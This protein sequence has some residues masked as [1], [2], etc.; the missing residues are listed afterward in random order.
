M[1]PEPESPPLGFRTIPCTGVD[2]S[3]RLYVVT[4]G[5]V[6]T[7]RLDPTKLEATLS[8]LVMHKFPRAGARV[9]LYELQIPEKFDSQNPPFVFT[10]QEHPEMY[11]GNGRPEI[12]N[13]FTGS[14]PCIPP[15][16]ELARFFQSETCP[17]SLADF[18]ER[19][20][21]AI[22]IHVT[23]FEG[24]TF[25]GFIAPHIVF[26][27]IGVATLLKAW[28]RLLRGEAIEN[29][30]GME[31]DAQP[32]APFMT[33]LVESEVPRGCFKPGAPRPVESC[34]EQD[35]SPP[36][37]S[38]P[39]YVPRFVRVPKVF[40][41][42]A[43]RNIM[44]ELK[45]QG[46]TE[47]VGSSD[48]LTAWWLKTVYG[49]R[50]PGDDTPIHVHISRNLRG[51]PVFANDAP[52]KAPYIHNAVSMIPVP[53]IPAC[54]FQTE[55]LGALALHIRRS[56]ITYNADLADVR[57]NLRW[58]CAVPQSIDR[59]DVLLCPSG[60]EWTLSVNWRSSNFGDL[61]FSG[62]AANKDSKMAPRVVFVYPFMQTDP[63][64]AFRGGIR[65]LME[66][67][68]AVWMSDTRGEEDWERIRRAGEIEFT[69]APLV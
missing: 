2:L 17:R 19:N 28:T 53:P 30:P 55:S 32:L 38:D 64:R 21:P 65:V 43:K 36:A 35:P 33:G 67:A 13:V 57:A 6:I 59:L 44:D 46:S 66:D 11:H 24:L 56:I 29:I 61:D 20:E 54:A 34:H 45:A 62:A 39:N 52:L 58:Y 48:V 49:H 63:P 68:D 9:A 27:A 42:E 22:H 40:L 41:N 15:D 4:I 18:I 3:K 25:L 69:D 10:A 16:P 47:Y 51:L 5:L 31:W 14:K 23:V 50:G 60:A 37:E 1:I 26:D 8:K 12:P 7:A